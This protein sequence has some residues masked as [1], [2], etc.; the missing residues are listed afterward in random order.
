MCRVQQALTEPGVFNVI[1]LPYSRFNY[2]VWFASLFNL[3][4]LRSNIK[5]VCRYLKYF[6]KAFPGRFSFTKKGNYES[7]SK[8]WKISRKL[9]GSF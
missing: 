2:D 8:F 6:V 5:S 7:S 4:L 1:G 9:K 3:L